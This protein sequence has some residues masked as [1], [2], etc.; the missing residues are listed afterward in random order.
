MMFETCFGVRCIEARGVGLAAHICGGAMMFLMRRGL[1]WVFG[2]VR[3]DN[4][5]AHVRGWRCEVFVAL[6]VWWFND[7]GSNISPDAGNRTL[8]HPG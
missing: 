2:V 4:V 7:V 6:M 3:S 8:G 5:C 1:V